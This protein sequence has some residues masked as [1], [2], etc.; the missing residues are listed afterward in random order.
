M[1]VHIV[2]RIKGGRQMV[3]L[4]CSDILKEYCSDRGGLYPF[5]SSSV[6]MIDISSV[7]CRMLVKIQSIHQEDTI[8]QGSRRKPAATCIPEV[9]NANSINSS[10]SKIKAQLT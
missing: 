10:S 9:A 2:Q 7:T 4:R 1:A 3:V 5:F 8:H 6:N